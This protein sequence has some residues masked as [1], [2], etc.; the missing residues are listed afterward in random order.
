[1]SHTRTKHIDI[2]HHFIRELVEDNEIRMEYVPTEQQFA[3]ILKKP[4]DARKFQQ[5]RA[6]LGIY[7]VN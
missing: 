7:N 2:G 3:D 5:L 4:L 1:M 6:A